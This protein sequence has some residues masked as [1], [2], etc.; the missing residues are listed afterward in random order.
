MKQYSKQIIKAM[1]GL[2]FAGAAFGAVVIVVELVAT[3]AGADG[4]SMAITVHL[5]ELLTYIGAPV[6]SGIV[7]YLLKSAFENRE[8]IKQHYM[9]DYDGPDNYGGYHE[10]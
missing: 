8:K 7:G 3:L 2:W 9:P 4:Y 6:G 5:P 10:N 1:V